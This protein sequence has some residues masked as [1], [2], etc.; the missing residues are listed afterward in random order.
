MVEV[1]RR[2]RPMTAREMATKYGISARSVRRVFAQPRAEYL[3]YSLS[4]VK[5]WEALG[6]SRATW[7]RQGKPTERQPDEK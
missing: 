1:I 2:K 5:P 6:M 4:R 7:Y 3:A